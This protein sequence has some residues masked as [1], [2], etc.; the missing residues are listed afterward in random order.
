MVADGA[1]PSGLLRF[2][3]LMIRRPPRSTLFPYTTLFRSRFGIT[4]EEFH[5]EMEH[6]AQLW[7]NEMV[8]TS[9]HDSK[10]SEDVRARINVL[11][12]MPL[13]WHR[14]VRDWRKLNLDKKTL[15]GEIQAP[16]ANDEYLFYQTLIGVWPFG[17]GNKGPD[18][19]FV[20]RICDFM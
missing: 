13:A 11:S 17:T 16:T 3:F 19:N 10:R 4:P 1:G 14:H 12:E 15:C 7:P 9:T 2:F 5:H 18:D 20:K 8:A 6:L